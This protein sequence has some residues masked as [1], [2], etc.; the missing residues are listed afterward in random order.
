MNINQT[1]IKSEINTQHY[2]GVRKNS[3]LSSYEILISIIPIPPQ[4]NQ[5]SSGGASVI[6]S[7]FRLNNNEHYP[8]ERLHFAPPL[9]NVQGVAHV[10]N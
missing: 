6:S 10:R 5:E 4:N 7:P 1:I 9:H 8:D 3:L 2:T